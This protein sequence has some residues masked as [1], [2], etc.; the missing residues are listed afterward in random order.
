MFKDHYES[1]LASRYASDR[2]LRL[3]SPDTRYQ[4]WRRLWT[5]LA[6]AEHQLGLPISEEQVQELEAHITD[7]DY[8]LAAQ[9]EREVRH[10]VM[11]HVYAYGKAA[12]SASGIIH[13]GATSCYVT[14]NADLILYREGLRYLREE[15][16]AVM[17]NL[18][19]FARTYKATPTLGYTHYQPAQLVT[20]G[21]RATLWLQDFLFDLEELDFVLEH[22]K[23]LGCRGT[24]G[25]EASFVDLFDGD[26][27]K[28]DDMNKKIAA[29]F[30]FMECYSV[31]GQ[32]YPR[33]TDS[34]ILNCLSAIAQS[35]YRMANDLRLLQHDRQI[36]E[37]FEKDQIGSSAMAYKRNPMRSE[38]ICSL[39]RY[40]MVNA[41]NAP[42][43]ASVQWMERTLDD[44]ANR[45][46]SMPEGFLC[47][48]AILRL[49]QNVTDGLH[50]NEKVIAASVREYLPFIATENLMMEA[51]KRGGNRQE[52]HEIIRTCSMAAT[53][54]MKEGEPCDLL[55]RLAAEPI[56][57]MTIEE[58]EA[59]LNPSAYIGR[60]PEQVEAFLAEVEPLL[61]GILAETADIDL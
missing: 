53:A 61:S 47:A 12:P 55:Q 14:D 6:R 39:S 18:A 38:R 27:D 45:R 60:C 17:A 26:T 2:M 7:I 15:L 56:F 57:G 25:T 59:V 20:V 31:C 51:V 52:L 43:T 11:A 5:A 54:K 42:L 8:N 22:M 28:I 32:T 9:R 13:L 33:K 30:G 19:E 21:K 23:F 10:D 46:I 49:V 4:T 58:M 44:S 1:P 50:V 34:R 24:T 41:L 37:P 3:F 40:L 16:L 29:E 36:E 35:C 48:D